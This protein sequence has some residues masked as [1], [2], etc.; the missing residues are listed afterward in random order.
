MSTPT[1][2]SHAHGN[3][4]QVWTTRKLL[5]WIS[6]R[7][8]D[9]GVDAPRVC[10]ELLVSSALGCDR[11]RLYM[12]PERVAS[13]SERD[14]LRDWVRRAGNHE[15]VQYLVGET[16]FNGRA[17]EVDRSTLIPRP[18][19]E[20]LVEHASHALEG[21]NGAR[22]L[23]IGTGTGCIIA[24]LLDALDRPSRA[25]S[26]RLEAL[27]ADQLPFQDQ[28]DAA[29]PPDPM[30][31]VMVEATAVATDVVPEALDLAG[32]NLRRHGYQQR[33]DLRI[34]ALFEPLQDHE[35]GGFDLLVSNPPYV[36][37]AEWA[38]CAANVREYEPER[39]LRGGKDGLDIIKP[40]FANASGVLKPGGY[41]A[42]E[43]QYDQASAVTAL[44]PDAALDF[45]A[46]HQD[47]EGHDRVLI[48]RSR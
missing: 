19:T 28:D 16:T 29:Q 38:K 45:V 7:L 8:E 37:D 2:G 18:S 41:V 33:V 17:F 20:T 13:N 26:R 5:E 34:G 35:F 6:T 47:H 36:S 48:A 24:S 4:D 46:V 12:E 27:K 9:A 40:L 3:P 39:A 14:R 15:P 44:L 32:R 22:I 10:S 30:P 21:V 31:E 43:I 1:T 23:E 25:E 11:L 42:V